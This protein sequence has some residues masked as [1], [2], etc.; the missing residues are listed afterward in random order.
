M[1]SGI[2]TQHNT[3]SNEYKYYTAPWTIYT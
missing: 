3:G 2:Y 1:T